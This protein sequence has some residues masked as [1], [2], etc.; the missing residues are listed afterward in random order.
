[1]AWFLNHYECYR[2]NRRWSDEWSC[3]CDDE[4]P[5]CE[6]RDN[7]P[8]RSNDLT[9][10]V[11]RRGAEFVVLRSP[12]TAEDDPDYFEVARFETEKQANEFFART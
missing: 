11:E 9:T 12:E 2:C 10:L 1:M 4:C 8:V 6:A 7:T 5:Y 3:M